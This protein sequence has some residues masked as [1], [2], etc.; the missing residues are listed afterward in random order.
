M[1]VLRKC[2][3]LMLSLLFAA[4]SAP[5]PRSA[6][7][8]SPQALFKGNDVSEA[9]VIRRSQLE[10]CQLIP[11]DTRRS[12]CVDQNDGLHDASACG[13]LACQQAAG[14]AA[15]RQRLAAWQN[16]V[17]RRTLINGAFD[18][19]LKDLDAFKKGPSYKGWKQ[20]G[21]NAM[22]E[23]IRKIKLGQSGHAIALKNAT[24]TLNDCKK[25][26]R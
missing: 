7:A 20:Q 6:P 3:L 2:V 14:A 1:N 5:V 9:D 21:K 16:C 12:T 17:D 11:Y 18:N 8:A 24:S 22:A 4:C 13:A 23:V 25:I 10:G 26:V 19:T 15:N